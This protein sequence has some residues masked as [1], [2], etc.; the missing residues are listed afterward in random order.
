MGIF[1]FMKKKDKGT[2]DL[3][4]PPAPPPSMREEETVEQESSL[5]EGIPPPPPLGDI[6]GK[7][8]EDGLKSPF[9]EDDLGEL[10]KEEDLLPPMESSA[11]MTPPEQTGSE[12]QPDSGM[13]EPLMEPVQPVGGPAPE[14]PEK[15]QPETQDKQTRY[16]RADRYNQMLKNFNMIRKDLKAFE[17]IMST[18]D[19]IERN[20]KKVYDQWHKSIAELQKKLNYADETLFKR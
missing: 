13:E 17:E 11:F 20:E 19:L 16:M 12:E 1:G 4:M 3:D 18:V 7:D 14:E 2:E 5:E 6:S 9:P 10:P 8:I 15:K